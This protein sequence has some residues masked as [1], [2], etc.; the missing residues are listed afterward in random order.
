M[1]GMHSFGMSAPIKVVAEH[2][3]FTVERVVAAAKQAMARKAVMKQAAILTERSETMQ[4][5]MIGLGRMGA[6][7]VDPPDEGGP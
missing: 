3:G 1:L 2:F 5:G 6:N 4:L 7:M